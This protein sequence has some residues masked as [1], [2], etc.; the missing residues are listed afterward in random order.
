MTVHK[1][2]SKGHSQSVID[3]YRGG[4]SDELD[5]LDNTGILRLRFYGVSDVLLRDCQASR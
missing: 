5:Y 2:I 3:K 1:V 4:V